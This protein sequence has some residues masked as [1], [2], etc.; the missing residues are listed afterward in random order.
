MRPPVSSQDRRVWLA[1]RSPRRR[2]LLETFGFEP[3]VH[4]SE[5]PEVP[6]PGESPTDYTRR[7][8]TTKGCAVRD[9]LAPEA[10]LAGPGWVIAAD[11]VVVLDGD[12]LEKPEDPAHA[13]ALLRRL[14]GRAHEVVTG[15]WVGEVDGEVSRAGVVT[16][17]VRFRPLSDGEIARYVQT[18]EPMD[19]AG[20]YGIQGLG[21]FMVEGIEGSWPN[22]VGLPV[23]E[24]LALMREVGALDEF[25]FVSEGM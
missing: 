13:R 9:A 16:T 11:T 10:R 21:G 8:A 4:S 12:I 18:G 20:A 24:V 23:N 6:E 19:K 2:A 17:A 7:L 1:S 25:P 15:F 5:V 3:L 14:S 22:V